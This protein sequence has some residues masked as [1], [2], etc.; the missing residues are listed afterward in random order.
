M[1]NIFIINAHEPWPF[2]V[3]RLNRTMV[4]HAT[5]NLKGKGYEIQ[6]TTMPD[7]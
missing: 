2:S 7:G 4:E 1:K 6:T 5:A 3:G